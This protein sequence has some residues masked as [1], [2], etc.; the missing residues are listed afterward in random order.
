MRIATLFTLITLTLGTTAAFAAENLEGNLAVTVSD[1][2]RAG[3]SAT[4]ELRAV[5]RRG[6]E[7]N[8]G[9][10]NREAR[11]HLLPM[12]W[13]L[14]DDASQELSATRT[15]ERAFRVDLPADLSTG[16][17]LLLT[18]TNDDDGNPVSVRSGLSSRDHKKYLRRQII[19]VRGADRGPFFRVHTEHTR[20]VFSPGEQFRVYVSA[21]G[22]Q[23]V[24]Q[25]VIVGLYPADRD[26]RPAMLARGTVSAA[27]GQSGTVAFDVTAAAS[28]A[29][30]PGDYRLV[31]IS[32]REIADSWRVRFVD[33][34]RPSGGGRWAHTFPF[35][36]SG[37]L[38]GSAALPQAMAAGNRQG[39]I[40]NVLD[41]IHNANLWVN[42]FGNAHP[43]VGPNPQLPE[44]DAGDLPPPAAIRRPSLTHATYQ[45]LMAQGVALGITMGYGEDYKAEAYMPL[46]T[47]HES[48]MDV[49]VRKYLNGALGYAA[50]PH[51]VAAYTD[52]YGHMEYTGGPELTGTE[53]RNVLNSYWDQARAAAGIGNLERPYRWTF[54]RK[55]WPSAMRDLL[56]DRNTGRAFNAYLN[57]R[58]DEHGGDKKW[59]ENHYTDDRARMAVWRSAWQAAGVN[60]IPDPP[61]YVPLPTLDDANAEH[62]GRQ[63]AYDYAS[64]A[65]RGVER[66]YG[67]ITDSL[68]AELP[69]IFTIHNKGTMNHSSVSHAWTGFRTPNI[70][71]AYL[72]GGATAISVSE[73]NL[74]SVPKPYFLTTFYN[75][76]L[77]DRGHPVYRA[78]LWKQAGS[79]TRWMRDAVFWAGRQIHTYFDQAGNMTWSHQGSD[80]T[81]YASNERMSSVTEFLGWYT[82]LFNKLEP[83][84]EVGLY[85]PPVGGPWGTG[86][87]RGHY[88]AMVSSLMSDYQVHMVSHGDIATG[89]LNRYP[90]IYAPSIHGPDSF[91]PFETE[92]FNAYLRQGGKIVVSQAP[93]YYHPEET[94]TRYGI[95]SRKVPQ[96]DSNTGQERRNRDGSVKMT[97]EWTESLEQWATVTREYV[98]GAFDPNGIV[99]APVNVH[100]T[101]THRDENGE[102]ATWRGSHWTGHH[103]WAPYRGSALDQYQALQAAFAQVRE[104][105]VIKDQPEVFT[106]LC[107]PEDANA[108]GHYLFAS[109][110]TLPSQP[111]L[112]EYRIPQ[113]FFK[114]MVEP[115][116]TTLKVRG[117]YGAVYDLI[118]AR[119]VPFTR[120]GD[121]IVFEAALDSVEGRIFALFPAPVAS[122]A[123]LTPTTV[124]AGT[125]LQAR[126][127]LR[128]ASG[129]ALG[130]LGSV[131]VEL[132]TSDGQHLADLRRAL[133][134]DGQLPDVLIPANAGQTLTL[135]VTDTVT[136]QVAETALN[137]AAAR[138]PVAGPADAITVYRG[139]RIH[140]WL[141]EASNVQIV[142]ESHR[143]SFN[144]AGEATAGDANPAAATERNWANQIANVVPGSRVVT[145]IDATT[146]R[147]WAHP[148][149]GDKAGA[150]TRHSVPNAHIDG[151][152]ILVGDPAT[153]STLNQIHR[154]Q[155]AQ[156]SLGSDNLGPGRAV[157]AWLPRA[158][159]A[160]HD[161]VVIAASDD[162]GLRAAADRLRQLA[163]RDPGPDAYYVAREAVR[164]AWSPSEVVEYKAQLGL[165]AGAAPVAATSGQAQEI[166]AAPGWAGLT[167]VLGTAIFSIDAGPAGVAVGTKSWARP[168]GL[169]S[170]DGDILGFWGGGNE[171]TPRDV[172][173]SANGQ[174]AWAGYSLLGRAAAYQAGTG[175]RVAHA[176]PL[177]YSTNN[178]FGWDS[179]KDS[180]RQLGMSPDHRTAIIIGAAEEGGII[181]YDADSGQ[182]KWRIARAGSHNRPRGGGHPQIA[183]SS[184]SSRVLLNTTMT[185]NP[186]EVEV[187]VKEQRYD[188][189]NNRY[190]KRDQFD[191]THRIRVIPTRDVLML[192]DVDSGRPVWQHTT[193]FRLID[194]ERGATVWQ[195][196]KAPEVVVQNR[197]RPDRT[198]TWKGA[199]EAVPNHN[200]RPVTPPELTPLAFWHLYSAIGPRGQWAIAG[201]REAK[202]TLYDQAG[203]PL[204]TWEPRHLPG[205]LSPGKMIPPYI[206]SGNAADRMV[207]FA[208][209]SRRLFV[210]EIRIGSQADRDAAAEAQ[211]TNRR[212]MRRITDELRNTRNYG[213]YGNRDYLDAFGRDIA[214]VPDDFRR[215]LIERMNRVPAERRAGRKRDYRFFQSLVD[216]IDRVLFQ[217]D[218]ALL[219]RAVGLS[220]QREIELDAMVHNGEADPNLNT[221]YVGCWDQTV[222]AI[223][224]ASGDE[225]WRTPVVGGCQISLATDANGRVTAVYAGGSRGDVY[226]LDPSSGAVV[227]Q[228]NITAATNQLS[229]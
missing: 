120:E 199:D 220:T 225:R 145:N 77:V 186:I 200:G 214:E 207:A 107:Q 20:C 3:G 143:I 170:A 84:R 197:T 116:T 204:R 39:H 38:D 117:D 66:I 40:T 63:A 110:W 4:V 91:Y 102:P 12:R 15:G 65:L 132:L 195:P 216:R 28:A 67:R 218:Q 25:E 217:E 53:R 182:E 92:G 190:N 155:I 108:R 128:D 74:D 58:K 144:R 196:G 100:D 131:R 194:S 136:G 149:S 173:V 118:G 164:F 180:D 109:N 1:N 201:T 64:F 126:L 14:F 148:W 221:I 23:A 206:Q 30:A 157:I 94:Y 175:R 178:P 162:A 179:F 123:L 16:W 160:S 13:N 56:K 119:A 177:V 35:G 124:T 89:G 212:L 70:D 172:G 83:V 41:R 17:Y 205:A 26:G 24:N 78:G 187:T 34:N 203:T 171:V 130:V 10:I 113:G 75:R 93:N 223:D 32:G 7:K 211:A 44:A 146:G 151:P 139:D 61:R 37:G 191:N 6:D 11:F 229:D 183:F 158:H 57:E 103:K 166:A 52:Y 210:F 2:L 165:T 59:F 129:A 133:P 27:A 153:N 5:D 228:R 141:Q 167:D 114:S 104:P 51:L 127:E 222:R 140:R 96:I 72:D 105:L 45:A 215:E 121:R 42:L 202:F 137:V 188:A 152:V 54:D 80:Q 9:L 86:A 69:A 209:Q 161:T 55:K 31:V 60:P 36:T 189:E 181:A 192:V 193:G 184:D 208:P 98:W 168:T 154:A 46:P 29:V 21:R 169:L 47:I 226:R 99:A 150:R 79:P 71:P 122:A 18:V 95:S 142:V 176:A 88:V 219:D 134:G 73:W 49:L 85:V 48:E 43:V 19:A 106:N 213:N 112:F 224:L 62:V 111:E 174:M 147:L 135:R 138:P 156:R 81:T 101:F 125:R 50:Y 90:I 227:W 115:V 82:D 163:Q 198:Q 185:A 97:T 33:P 76:P 22:P 68:E 159:S 87:T 8:A